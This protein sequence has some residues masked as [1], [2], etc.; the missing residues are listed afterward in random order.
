MPYDITITRR[1][2]NGKTEYSVTG[3][4]K[5]EPVDP[6][7]IEKLENETPIEQIKESIKAKQMKKLGLAEEEKGGEEKPQGLAGR[8]PDAEALNPADIPF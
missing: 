2:N 7:V 5:W 8:Y 1:E 4:P 6:K 3:S